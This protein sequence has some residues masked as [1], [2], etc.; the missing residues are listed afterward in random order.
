M[1]TTIE[2]IKQ[3][4]IDNDYDGLVSEHADCGCV[5]NDLQPCG[6]DFAT[7]RP[8]YKYADPENEFQF[9]ICDELQQGKERLKL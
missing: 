6:M 2:I 3:Y 4:L 1:T 9:V 5:T 7:C 8:G